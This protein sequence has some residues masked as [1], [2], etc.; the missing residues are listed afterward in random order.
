MSEGQWDGKKEGERTRDS[1]SQQL[2][3]SHTAL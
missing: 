1:Q 3:L 2:H